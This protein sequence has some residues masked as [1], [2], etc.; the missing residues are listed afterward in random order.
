VNPQVEQL[1][2][3][4]HADPDDTQAYEA[5]KDIL[6]Q[7]GDFASLA[8]LLEGRASRLFVSD[9]PGASVAY[10]EAAELALQG[11]ANFVRV[12]DLYQKALRLNPLNQP[13]TEGLQWLLENHGQHQALVE[14]LQNHIAILESNPGTNLKYLALLKFRLGELWN[15]RFEFSDLALT[16][17]LDA[18]QLDPTL[19]AAI[20]EA[21][22]I[23]LGNG[24][25]RQAAELYDQ[26]AEAE[27]NIERKVLLL[28]ESAEVRGQQL[29]DVDGAINTLRNVL[30]ILPD[31]IQLINDLVGYLIQRA[32]NSDK[33]QADGDYHAAADLLYRLARKE[34]SAS[35]LNYVRQ[36]L[37]CVPNHLAALEYLEQLAREL[38]EEEILPEYWVRYL[39]LA[40]E[41]PD[42]DQ[43]RLS[44][45]RAYCHAK[46]WED[47]VFCIEP[48]ARRGNLQAQEVL[49]DL[50][51]KL[52]RTV[53]GI[54]LHQLELSREPDDS[55]PEGLLHKSGTD[56]ATERAQ[57]RSAPMPEKPAEV[58]SGAFEL[59]REPASEP[60]I[61]DDERNLGQQLE[62]PAAREEQIRGEIFAASNPSTESGSLLDQSSDETDKGDIDEEL[63]EL[64]RTM[65]DQGKLPGKSENGNEVC[66]GTG[67]LDAQLETFETP[68]NPRFDQFLASLETVT[69]HGTDK[70]TA[71][72]PVQPGTP[73]G[74]SLTQ[75]FELDP[76]T[77]DTF[78]ALC[79]ALERSKKY[80]E[81]AVRLRERAKSDMDAATSAALYKRAALLL[82]SR[83]HDD[84]AAAEAWRSVLECKEDREAL[85]FLRWQAV[86]RN[87]NETLAD[88]LKRLAALE[89]DLT[90][91]RDLLYDYARLLNV[92]LKRPDQAVRVLRQIIEEIDPDFELAVDELVKAAEAC[93]DKAALAQGLE[94]RLAAKK[95]PEA[96]VR[97]A[98]RLAELYQDEEV[99]DL[100][101]ATEALWAWVKAGGQNPEPYRQLKRIYEEQKRWPEL[102]GVLD[103]LAT[104]EPKSTARRQAALRACE[105]VSKE[106]GDVDIGWNRLLALVEQRVEGAYEMLAALAIESGQE[107]VLCDLLERSGRYKELVEVL[108]AWASRESIDEVKVEVCRR[109]ARA[110]K[111]FFKD[112]VGE[113]TAWLSLLNVKEDT[114]AL[115]FLRLE[116][117]EKDDAEQL[118][119]S[120][121]RLA[122]LQN[123]VSLRRDLLFEHAKV[124]R[125]RLNRPE[126]AIE[127]LRAILDDVDPGFAPAM[128]ELVAVCEA[129]GNRS[130]WIETLELKLALEKNPRAAE[131][132]AQ[133]L[134]DIYRRESRDPQKEIAVY[135]RWAE[136]DSRNTEPL[137]QMV[138]RL[139][140]AQRWQELL[141]SL[142]ALALIEPEIEA[143]TA[144]A[145]RAAD[146]AYKK[147]MD[148]AG[149]IER[150]V[151]LVEQGVPEA[152]EAAIAVAAETGRLEKLREL[153]GRMG[154]YPSSVRL[155]RER[156]KVEPDKDAR[157]EIFRRIA[158]IASDKL[159]DES[160]A[161]KAWQNL[162]EIQEDRDALRFIRARA[163]KS[164]DFERQADALKRLVAIESDTTVQR[165]LLL[166]CA[167]ILSWR[168]GRPQEATGLL[169]RIL[170]ELHAEY[171]PAIEELVKTCE[172]VGDLKA[173]ADALERQ[174]ISQHDPLTRVRLA[175]RLA[176][177]CERDLNDIPRAVKVVKVWC[178]ANDADPKPHRILKR[179]FERTEHWEELLLAADALARLEP[180]S[181]ERGQAAVFAAQIA[182][183]R[184]KD[185][186][187]AW[188]RLVPF[189]QQGEARAI[190]IA[191]Q[192]AREAGWGEALAN[193]F[194]SVA[195]RTDDPQ[196]AAGYWERAAKAFE[197]Y[198]EKPE[199][200]FEATLRKLATDL[201]NREFLAQ[202]DR[203]AIKLQAWPRL[204][205]VYGRLVKEAKKDGEK[206]E[207]LLRHADILDKNANN[208][209]VA[210]DQVMEAGKIDPSNPAWLDRAEN[211]CIRSHRNAELLAIYER[212]SSNSK[213]GQ[214]RVQWLLRAAQLTSHE[215][216]DRDTAYRYIEKAARITELSDELAEQIE[217]VAKALD[218]GS[219]G[220]TKQNARQKL[221]DAYK[222]IALS[223]NGTFAPSLLLRAA[224]ILSE[225]L[226]D[227]HRAFETLREGVN[228]FPGNQ[229][230][231]AVCET[232]AEKIGRLDALDALLSR[233]GKQLTG[234]PELVMWLE[235]RA[236]LLEQRLRRYDEA[237]N[238]YLK[239]LD[240]DPT[241]V[242][243]VK[244]L[245]PCLEKAGRY[246]ELVRHIERQ[247]ERIEGRSEKIE[248][249]KDVAS[250]WEEH[251]MDRWAAVEV[252]RQVLAIEPE[253]KQAKAALERLG[254]QSP[255]STAPPHPPI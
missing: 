247:A 31:D 136:V 28:A 16:C 221:I 5:L 166:D 69:V 55:P 217:K 209:T 27:T 120:L 206:V 119:G 150:L 100:T 70:P 183:Q 80:P 250:I 230:I 189:I 211:L 200:A 164:G 41:T 11:A 138:P 255:A 91:K 176:E 77:P 188:K 142:D 110:C 97:I 187:G 1:K 38:K 86:K 249:L 202:V 107:K 133:Q 201:N 139:E 157:A 251:L 23:Y 56:G 2:T 99:R 83:L 163:E 29:K 58:N 167:Q 154:K 37:K 60:P 114:E 30:S 15:K 22:E 121:K 24:D 214:E 44:L 113:K 90:E 43:R 36:A 193:L 124:L 128:D 122:A 234:K 51:N 72:S 237:A 153:F 21:R 213:N 74:A 182:L 63:T 131:T 192:L 102:V 222:G 25:L 191:E 115:E 9:R 219:V 61:E 39:A 186:Q 126:E 233:L 57:E 240:L 194:V 159:D 78:S 101:G 185:A 64:D 127:V 46:Q 227:D 89:T 96:R 85:E 190:E 13:A 98:R 216:R 75:A 53:P 175:Q 10:Q 14:F 253:D 50:N 252:W 104:M 245:R 103:K 207:L 106:M 236:Q 17:Y 87:D 35:G 116:A 144:A 184:L 223:G 65:P 238:V 155:L 4:L 54:D 160:G 66:E 95:Q 118:A 112:R 123:D 8:E 79:D 48:A 130:P 215:I 6:A 34:P 171:E 40:P 109:L 145:L 26:E 199:P 205:Q 73:R 45:A 228:R 226:R 59:F 105:V 94:R 67:V 52:G 196:L 49:R 204:A 132:L 32:A 232:T 71:Q 140:E 242:R 84:Q 246:L 225:E 151:T 181:E 248:I 203:L 208:P 20:F 62:L 81:L 141:S 129:T 161:E 42:A 174:L 212:R 195:Q 125:E 210:L 165:D 173:L 168:I 93:G 177:L 235:R 18:A 180:R 197:E 135:Q 134:L 224:R 149:A 243:A 198:S 82:S 12:K 179:L 137:R 68:D 117:S 76:E 169:V 146:V 108:R 88:L 254:R 156:A 147:L 158:L 7:Q 229:E 162:L 152:E 218:Q 170:E 239:L 220:E 143:R 172:A 47:A 3:K 92:R 111:L 244:A 19:L 231:Y 33:D 178:D 241:H 148:G